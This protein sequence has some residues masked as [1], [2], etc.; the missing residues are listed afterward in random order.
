[1]EEDDLTAPKSHDEKLLELEANYFGATEAPDDAA[2]DQRAARERGIPTEM[3]AASRDIIK[4]EDGLKEVRQIATD[5]PRLGDWMRKIENYQVSKDDQK[6][7]GLMEGV[8]SFF[9]NAPSTIPAA[10]AGLMEGGLGFIALTDQ[11]MSRALGMEEDAEGQKRLLEGAR[12]F[13]QIREAYQPQTGNTEVDAA[14]QGSTSLFQ[15]LPYIAAGFATRN[16]A[17]ATQGLSSTVSGQEYLEA[18]NQGM[19][20]MDA[21]MFGVGQGAI[22][23]LTERIPVG[24]LLGDSGKRYIKKWGKAFIE[25]Q[26]T[27][28]VATHSQDFLSWRILP[29]N[30][31]KTWDHYVE[32][33]P[34]AA[35]QT[36][37][38]TAVAAG[39]MNTVVI[40]G[41]AMVDRLSQRAQAAQPSEGERKL[42]E[43]FDVAA[44]SKTR[45]R[46]PDAFLEF[47]DSLTEG[48]DIQ[49]VSVDVDGLSE[50][51]NQSGEDAAVIFEQMG[52]D[53]ETVAT[54][55]QVEVQTRMMLSSEVVQSNRETILRHTRLNQ[56][57]FTPAQRELEAEAV[58]VESANLEKLIEDEMK[59]ALEQATE[60]FD[61]RQELADR[62]RD[63]GIYEEGVVNIQADA[64][65]AI[66]ETVAQATG[67]DVSA[68][69]PTIHGLIEEQTAHAEATLAQEVETM[70]VD[71]LESSTAWRSM[72]L[73][74]PGAGGTQVEVEAGVAYDNIT[75][76]RA[77]AQQM[78]DCIN[79]A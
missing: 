29:D 30:K 31:D 20:G 67:E 56:D 64:A 79:A 7:L 45:T 52:L 48:A 71:P 39:G 9:Y 3:A 50:A 70:T 46:A 49:T 14:L 66:V 76:R 75:Q 53:A 27:E 43:L 63:T 68:I 11:I 16:P 19:D 58:Q 28:Q 77:A 26:V 13:R 60:A 4:E 72:K 17:L 33:R 61:T 57:T 38:A 8:A 2:Y 78:L 23:Y 22:E 5:S 32:E 54:G 35:Y 59:V 15:M 25:E 40:G 12:D 42:H 65:A 6:Q 44:E 24:T 74:V 34:D 55:G 47:I 62:L 18:K 36:M 1:M 73:K 51:L 21:A 37:I 41:E 10:G 69:M